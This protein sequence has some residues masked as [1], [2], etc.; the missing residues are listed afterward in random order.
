[1]LAHQHLMS[2]HPTPPCVDDE[3]SETFTHMEGWAV[4]FTFGGVLPVAGNPPT[5]VTRKA[6]F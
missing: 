3:R 6:S 4:R 5:Q 1:M 2:E